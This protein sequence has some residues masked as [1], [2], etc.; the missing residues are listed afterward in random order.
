MLVR[1]KK[2]RCLVKWNSVS[3]IVFTHLLASFES[4]SSVKCPHQ[5]TPLNQMSRYHVPS[6]IYLAFCTGSDPRCES[7]HAQSYCSYTQIHVH[8]LIQLLLLITRSE[9]RNN[10]CLC[11]VPKFFSP[12][13]TIHLSH[14]IF[15][16]M[17]G[18]LN[19]GK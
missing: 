14:Q 3:C 2:G 10:Y 9:F 15:C 5:M 1:Y 7:T 11:L 8:L 16:L 4:E 13:F 17:H 18:A 6:A 12:N 19:V